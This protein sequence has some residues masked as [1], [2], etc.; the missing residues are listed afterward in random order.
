MMIVLYG[1]WCNKTQSWLIEMS[2]FIDP[3]DFALHLGRQLPEKSFIVSDG[4]F[5]WY[6]VIILGN[7]KDS[8]DIANWR[9]ELKYINLWNVIS[10]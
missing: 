9:K 5:S 10:T 7:K 4:Y 2:I 1:T 8:S 6:I 3:L